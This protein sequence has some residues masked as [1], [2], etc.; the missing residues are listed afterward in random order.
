MLLRDNDHVLFYGDSITDAGRRAEQNNNQGLGHGYAAITAAL[1]GARHA[2]MNLRFTN[3]GISG[4]RV[5]D[6]E[7]RLEADLLDHAPDVVSVL[8]G[9]N[10]TWRRYDRDVVSPVDEFD[11]CYRRILERIR[12]RLGAR[13]VICEPFL[14]PTP[15]DRAAW[16]EDLDPRIEAVRAIASD[17][18]ATLI[19]FD[20]FFAAAAQ[21]RRPDYW[22]PDGVHPSPA[23]H[24]LM[25]EAWIDEVTG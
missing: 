20:E 14:L 21:R 16:R 24:A 10:D 17:F 12:E 6:L 7:D 5:Y 22:L 3:M 23:G 13:L 2:E 8:I 1:L 11:A 18:G 19:A 15:P 25:A 4:N 9:I